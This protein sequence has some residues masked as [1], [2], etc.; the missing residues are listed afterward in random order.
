MITWKRAFDLIAVGCLLPAV[1][2]LSLVIGVLVRI[3]IGPPVVFRQTRT[4]YHGCPF[5]MFKFRTMTPE[6]D[7]TGRL[8]S[9]DERTPPFA[10]FLRKTSLDELPELLNVLKGEMSLVGPRPLLMKYLPYYSA[11]ERKRFDVPPGLTGWAQIHGR[12]NK[13]WNERLEMDAWY[14]DNISLALDLK[15]IALTVGKVLRGDDVLPE[16]GIAVPDLDVERQQS[17]VTSGAFSDQRRANTS[18]S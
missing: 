13:P 10:V 15:I 6:R 14:A 8:L 4:G 5:T 2:P 11:R 12:S 7:E 3:M 9:D 16:N 1:V 18:E 17:G